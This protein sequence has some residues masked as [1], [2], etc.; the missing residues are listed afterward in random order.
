MK[1]RENTKFSNMAINIRRIKS[2]YWYS[3]L[4]LLAIKSRF[5]HNLLINW[6]KP[7]FLDEIKMAKVTEKDNVLLIGCGMFP[8]ETM[9]IYEETKANVIGI[10]NSPITVKMASKYIKKNSISD[11]ITI[12]YGDG[13][14]YPVNNFDKIFIAINVWPID[15]V[16]KNLSKNMKQ[17]ASVL[18]RGMKSDIDDI[19]KDEE[20]LKNFKVQSAVK[21]TKVESYLLIK[22]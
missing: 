9:I 18:C 6:R 14:D 3:F 22:R 13:A 20:M 17:N 8:T 7:V 16:L 2:C 11:F 5:F 19:L 15:S 12:E 1:K 4:E 10:D 21:R